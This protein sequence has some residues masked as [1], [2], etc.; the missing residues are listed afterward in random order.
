VRAGGLGHDI[1]G[2]VLVG[3]SASAGGLAWSAPWEAG[4]LTGLVLAG[5]VLGVG[6]GPLPLA[7]ARRLSVHGAALVAALAFLLAAARASSRIAAHARESDRIVASGP[8]PARCEI[9]GQVARSPLEMGDAV[10]LEIALEPHEASPCARAGRVVLHV[11]RAAAP[12]LGRGDRV[13]AVADLAPPHRFWN[14]DLGDPRPAMARRGAHLTGGALDVVVL[15]RG[16]GLGHGIDRVRAHLRARIRATFPPATE[17]MARALVLGEDDLAAG[18]QRAFRRS[19][20]A[21]LL[22][23]SGMH[24]VLVIAGLVALLR[25]AFVRVPAITARVAP[26]RVAAAVAIPAAWLYADLAGRSGSALR[27]A[28]MTSVGLS[29]HV[30]A[31]RP[32]TWR[33]FGLSVVLMTLL[34]PL[35]AHDLSFLL[36]AAA[37]AGILA[38]APLFTGWV[39]RVWPAAAGVGRE[40]GGSGDAGAKRAPGAPRP[41][42]EAWAGAVTRT[43]AASTAAAIACAPVL[44]TMTP[45]LPLVGLV[46]NLV[47]IPIGELAAL[48]L[49]LVHALLSPLPD[50]ER[51]TALVASG[52]L[53]LVR[54]VARLASMG[55]W[56]ALPVPAPTAAQLAALAALPW[57]AAWSPHRSRRL[58][59]ASGLA[60]LA[61]IG[62]AEVQ[63]RAR[64]QPRGLLRVTFLDVGQ[65]DAAVIDLPDGSAVLVDAGGL[66]GSPLDTGE[67]V[68]APV[69]RARR[70][71]TLA[72]AILSHPH[73]DHYGGLAASLSAVIPVALWDTGQGEVESDGRGGPLLALLADLRSRGIPVLRPA[74]LCGTH[75]LGGARVDVLAPCPSFDGDHGPNDNS[76]VVRVAFGER[77][78]LFVGDAERHEEQL[79]VDRHGASLRADVLKVGHHGSRTSSSP[80]FLAAVGPELAIVS[81]GVRNRFGHPA[82]GTLRALAAAHARVFRTDRDGAVTVTTD[83]RSLDVRTAAE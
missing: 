75:Q 64:S 17:S 68:V 56:S 82:P 66:V 74:E 76:F 10:R 39:E 7:R 29:A 35:A 78:F 48:P 59:W 69:L 47:A 52:A 43:L 62:L 6:S 20:L 4:T 11:P 28:I 27:A 44:A 73:P 18:D 16:L 53:S 42:R 19:G 34:D 79:L 32:D 21:H 80:A 2:A 38:L 83:G 33:A 5:V 58:R 77:A 24:L 41:W 81:C 22:A 60:C 70:R 31:R 71:G 45:E 67:R 12:V 30:V 9:R 13:A 57:V 49:C 65:G 14:G 37:T 72:A 26:L 3:L 51:G 40:A 8:W 50:A 61:V 25:A 15:G 23:V 54:A 55:R 46:A 63:A 1:D 36:S